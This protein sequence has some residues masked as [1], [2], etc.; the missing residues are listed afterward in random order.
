MQRNGIWARTRLTEGK[1][2]RR[3]DI[4]WALLASSLLK[5][6]LD[7]SDPPRAPNVYVVQKLSEYRDSDALTELVYPKNCSFCSWIVLISAYAEH[8]SGLGLSL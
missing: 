6:S 1:R 2:F 3:N 5:R 8:V 4:Q 7:L